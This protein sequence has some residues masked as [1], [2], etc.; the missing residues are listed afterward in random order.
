MKKSSRI[1]QFAKTPLFIAMACA[2]W[3]SAAQ[4]GEVI[5]LPEFNT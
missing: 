3:M 4:A 5:D 2:G 1:N